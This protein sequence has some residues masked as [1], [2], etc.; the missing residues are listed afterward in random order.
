VHRQLRA[1]LEA[2]Y[3]SH[4]QRI[5]DDGGRMCVAERGGVTVGV[6]VYRMYRNTV[7]GLHLYVDDL[8]TD[9][10]ARSSGVGKAL[11]DHLIA[12]ARTAGC[13]TFTLDSGLQRQRAHAFYL[14]EGLY[15]RGYHFAKKLD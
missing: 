5:F 2:D 7:D 3:I 9:E 6:A 10:K 13:K 4:M 1:Q 12:L 11:L 14:R 8:V 15:I